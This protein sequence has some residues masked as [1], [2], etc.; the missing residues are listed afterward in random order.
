MVKL[1][2]VERDGIICRGTERDNYVLDVN[3]N[4]NVNVN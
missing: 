3:V 2:S 1:K 4:V